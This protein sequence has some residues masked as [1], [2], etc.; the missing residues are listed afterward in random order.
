MDPVVQAAKRKKETEERH[1][2]LLDL[3][4]KK[5]RTAEYLEG[6]DGPFILGRGPQ[7]L[8]LLQLT[9]SV[10][11]PY[12]YVKPYV[13]YLWGDTDCG[14]SRSGR[15]WLRDVC[16]LPPSEVWIFLESEGSKWRDQYE[17]H[18]AVIWDDL[19]GGLTQK[20]MRNTLDGYEHPVEQKNG[21]TVWCPR[22]IVITSDRAPED[23]ELKGIDKKTGEPIKMLG[24][25]IAQIKRR[26]SKIIHFQTPRPGQISYPPEMPPRPEVLDQRE[27]VQAGPDLPVLGQNLLEEEADG[28]IGQLRL[29]IPNYSADHAE[30]DW[31]QLRLDSPGGPEPLGFDLLV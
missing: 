14:K 6:P 21:G 20:R 2:R 15:E 10:P 4:K 29:Q 24:H 7:A 8:K 13:L 25:E 22:V 23:L 3:A 18:L 17:R 9:Y 11:N 31:E 19:T 26:I 27:E 30:E 5:A 12:V 28:Q 16:R 1:L